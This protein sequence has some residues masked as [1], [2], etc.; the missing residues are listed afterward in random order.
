[1]VL[2]GDDDQT[3]YSWAGASPEGMLLPDIPDDHKCFLTQSQRVPQMIHALAEQLIRR[4]SHRHE[5]IYGPR[6]AAGAVQRL[7]QGYKSPEYLILKTL[8]RNLAQGK[9]IMFLGSCSYML[10][11]ILRILRKE[12]IRYHNPY[13]KSN[14]FWNPL[15]TNSRKSAASRIQA[16]LVAHPGFGPGY[17]MWRGRELSL[18]TEWLPTGMLTDMGPEVIAAL[19]PMKDVTLEILGAI[20]REH[21]LAAIF[22]ALGASTPAALLDWWKD[23]VALVFRKWIQVPVHVAA[24]RGGQSLVDE[25]PVIRAIA[26]RFEALLAVGAPSK[27]HTF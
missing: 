8:E 13:R 23:R 15:R 26:R 5:N 14:G 6:A 17:H 19:P 3:I 12:A 18:W 27:W 16:L 20:F 21:T 7:S 4:V 24:R 10:H 2:A 11:P 9:R 22:A 25:P 1:L